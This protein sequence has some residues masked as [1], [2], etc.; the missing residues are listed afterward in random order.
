MAAAAEEIRSPG[1]VAARH[2]A[3]ILAQHATLRGMVESLFRGAAAAESGQDPDGSILKRRLLALGFALDRHLLDEEDLLEPL[4]A[5]ADGA[6][7]PFLARMNEEHARQRAVIARLRSDPEGETSLLD[8]AA[9]AAAIGRALL[10]EMDEE[11]R[12][13]LTLQAF[14]DRPPPPLKTSAS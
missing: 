6:G 2:R 11:E 7:A 14:A 13:L 1:P 9:R 12:Q 5:R 8:L 4:F 3:E 10:E